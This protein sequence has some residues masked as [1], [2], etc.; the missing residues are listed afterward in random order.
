[1]CQTLLSFLFFRVL[2]SHMYFMYCAL[3]LC[4]V[5]YFYVLCTI[6]M[7]CALFFSNNLPDLIVQRQ[8]FRV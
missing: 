2:N 3:F 4:L 8:H 1:M 5:H 6:S 7:S